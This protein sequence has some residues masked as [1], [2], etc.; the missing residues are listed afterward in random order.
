MTIFGRDL[1][2]ANL[3]KANRNVSVVRSVT[4]SRCTALVAAQVNRH[5]YTFSSS[6]LNRTY[7][8]PV[9]STPVTV[10]GGA[11]NVRIFGSGGGSGAVYGLPL[12][13]LQVIHLRIIALTHC[14]PL[15][16]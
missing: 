10:K 16:I 6:E 5:M 3:R 2:L 11:S 9:K 4:I 15:G 12:C 8:A 1:R 14:L 7:N 13:F